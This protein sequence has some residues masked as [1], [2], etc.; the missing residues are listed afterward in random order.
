[1]MAISVACISLKELILREEIEEVEPL[2]IAA[3]CYDFE[4]LRVLLPTKL[5][6]RMTR[7]DDALQGNIMARTGV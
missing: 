1:M 2:S 3:Y 7:L 5:R 4:I 6:P